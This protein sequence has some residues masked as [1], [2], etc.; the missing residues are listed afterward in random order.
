MKAAIDVLAELPGPRLLVMGDMGEVGDQGPRFH[1][2]AGALARAGGIDMLFM[3]GE[4]SENAG[5]AFGA[6]R[7]FRTMETL[8]AAVLVELPRL[9]SVLVK[10]SRFMKMERV[11]QAIA[12]HTQTDYKGA[13]HAA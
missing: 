7:H 8:I 2:E 11:I 1:A 9:A 4:Q 3:I 10:G 6:G 5:A 12:E 13:H